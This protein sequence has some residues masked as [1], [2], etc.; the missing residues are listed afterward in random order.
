[1]SPNET[2]KEPPIL[3]LVWPHEI[4]LGAVIAYGFYET[5]RTELRGSPWPIVFF[6][7]G[8]VSMLIILVLRGLDDWRALPNKLFFF[9]LAAA[10]VAFFTV[11]GNS[12]FG[13]ID[14]NSIFAWAF[15]IYTA[16]NADTGDI[17]YGLIIPYAVL[18]LYW[19]KRK[20]LQAQ[21]VVVWPPA[22]GYIFVAL[23][24]HLL[25]YTIQQ[26]RMSYLGFFIGLYGLTGLA[27][28]KKWLQSSMF[29]YFL[30]LFC[31][32]A[33]GTNWLTLHMRLMVS[34]IVAGIAHLGLAPDLIRDG[35]QLF[36]AQHTFAFEVVAACSGI[37]SL[38][39]LLALTIIYGFLVFKSPWKRLVMVLSAF[40]LSI[41]ANVVRLCFTILVAELAGQKA[42]KAVE[43]NAGF[44]TFSVAILCVYFLARK[45]EKTGPQP[46][47]QP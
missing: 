20:E 38:T 44:V 7:A 2:Q 28:G 35:T 27:W 42:G 16:P 36:D 40:P 4:P 1:V 13:Y 5:T 18:V 12:T 21:P 22:L 32:P 33:F 3:G 29:P 39:A 19:W 41:L 30:L 26:P 46:Q 31:I 37:R 34:W 45:L 43:S 25:G 17:E 10:W 6:G 11:L 9:T 14:S 8:L 15:D 23:F 47:P 24:V